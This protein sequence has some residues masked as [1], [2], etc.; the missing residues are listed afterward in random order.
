[1]MQTLWLETKAAVAAAIDGSCTFEEYVNYHET[2][3]LKEC[4]EIMS[5]ADINHY[6]ILSM[7][8]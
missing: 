8:N 2:L 6:L 7:N 1:M 3:E 5:M 4:A